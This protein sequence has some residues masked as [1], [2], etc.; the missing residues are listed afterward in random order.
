MREFT[1]A[2]AEPLADAA[3]AH[4]MRFDGDEDLCFALYRSSTGR[5]RDSA[6]LFDLLL[7]RDGE[8]S[9]HG[10]ASFTTEYLRRAIATAH[11][12]D[13]GIA[14]LHSHPPR[15]S[16][17]QELSRD[18]R[19]GESRHAAVV[20]DALKLPLVGLTL[21]GDRTWSAR[22][23]V[24]DENH[25]V[26]GNAS[27][28]VRVVG[29]RLDISINPICVATSQETQV[30]TLSFWGAKNQE[31][32]A[33]LTVAIVGLGSVGSIVAELLAR[34]GVQRLILIDFD[35]IKN[36]NLDR[37]ISATSNHE[38][39]W[40]VDVAADRV[41]AI[42][43]AANFRVQAVNA[44]VVEEDGYA[45]LLDADVTFSCVDRPWA[46][47]VLN[48][49]AYAH[50]IPVIDGGILVRFRPGGRDMLNADWSVH[51]GGPGRACL[52]CQR[53]Y[54]LEQVSLE[55]TGL[56]DDEG[57][58]RNLPDASVASFEVLQLVAMVSGLM[59]LPD[60]GQQRYAYYPG[61]V[62][63][64]RVPSCY[65]ECMTPRF[66]AMADCVPAVTGYDHGRAA[67]L[68]SLR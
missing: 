47:H 23:W 46:R 33:S 48:R 12:A 51:T 6:V 17:W 44:S 57:Y 5:S 40:K 43:T 63:V 14:L 32:L 9:V 10:N 64:E 56:L 34:T 36:H 16:G 28:V 55:Q 1:V 35:V 11:S 59:G 66:T 21:A 52:I 18:D 2:M 41:R 37:T 24:L 68:A 49:I 20:F 39:L 54:T 30:R 50:L 65:P 42:A 62:R 38:G 4:L 19:D 26:L 27:R 3:A 45:A 29:C 61:N 60:P 25:D 15:T 13:A 7:P 58:I 53:A 22:R 67:L 31:S 8:R